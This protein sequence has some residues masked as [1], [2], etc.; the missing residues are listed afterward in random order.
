ME[1][2]VWVRGDGG[3]RGDEVGGCSKI[4]Y[5]IASMERVEHNTTISHYVMNEYGIEAFKVFR[6]LLGGGF[7]WTECYVL[8]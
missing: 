2:V 3:Q 1:E 6:F 5:E 4:K 8:K 7:Y